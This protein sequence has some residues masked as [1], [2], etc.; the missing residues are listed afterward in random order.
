MV[1]RQNISLFEGVLNL[2]HLPLFGLLSN[3]LKKKHKKKIPV[4]SLNES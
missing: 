3:Y 2:V 4:R 1:Q